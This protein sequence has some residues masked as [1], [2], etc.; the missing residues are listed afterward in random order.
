MDPYGNI[1]IFLNYFRGNDR[2][3]FN[4][5]SFD[6][7]NS[8]GMSPVNTYEENVDCNC[9]FD[10]WVDDESTAPLYD[11][12]SCN[13]TGTRVRITYGED[14]YKYLADNAKDYLKKLLN[15]ALKELK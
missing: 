6:Y 3:L 15:G 9:H 10:N 13:G 14:K 1:K 2:E 11:C 7:S 5:I 12:K 4:W 8:S